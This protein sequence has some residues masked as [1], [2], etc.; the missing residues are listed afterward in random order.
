MQLYWF[1]GLPVWTFA[2]FNHYKE[3]RV[4]LE[5]DSYELNP[6]VLTMAADV[7]VHHSSES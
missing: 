3:A 4:I 5:M 7:S 1:C 2:L 6:R